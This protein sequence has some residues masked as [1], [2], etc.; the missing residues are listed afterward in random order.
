[1]VAELDEKLAKVQAELE[2]KIVHL[3]TR[4]KIMNMMLSA[5]KEGPAKKKDDDP[6]YP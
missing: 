1:M 5:K 3:T 6:N 2:Q 4:I